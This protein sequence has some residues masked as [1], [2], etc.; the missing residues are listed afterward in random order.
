MY[1]SDM[2]I[3]QARAERVRLERELLGMARRGEHSPAREQVEWDYE[4]VCE[5]VHEL[6]P[7]EDA[8]VRP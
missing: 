3:E 5:R 2:T 6:D 7:A 8:Q 4:D 1:T